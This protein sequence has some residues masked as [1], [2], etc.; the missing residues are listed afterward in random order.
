MALENRDYESL[1]SVFE[2]PRGPASTVLDPA[3]L[4]EVLH[5][6]SGRDYY[7][8]IENLR[9]KL[10]NQN[11][12]L[13]ALIPNHFLLRGL[14]TWWLRIL[15]SSFT[16]FLDIGSSEKL[17]LHFQK[18]KLHEYGKVR[19]PLEPEKV[20]PG[21]QI[22]QISKENWQRLSES[23]RPWP[24]VAQLLKQGEIKLFP[25]RFFVTV[26]IATRAVFGL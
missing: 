10:P 22:I 15:P 21:S 12:E 11:Q 13:P 19:N 25:N 20:G 16:I 24:M 5:S 23:S 14:R 17:R 7:S 3:L 6:V 4:K 26:L 2:G 9:S 18:G 1:R 8:Q